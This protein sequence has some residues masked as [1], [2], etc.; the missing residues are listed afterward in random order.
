MGLKWN[1]RS[2][3]FSDN[4]STA[5]F[6]HLTLSADDIDGD[7]EPYSIYVENRGKFVPPDQRISYI[8]RC[9]D[10]FGGIDEARKRAEYLARCYF[11][12][13][14]PVYTD[15]EMKNGEVGEVEK[16]I[17]RKPSTMLHG[18]WVRGI[19]YHPELQTYI[20]V[21][22]IANVETNTPHPLTLLM[23]SPTVIFKD[24]YRDRKSVV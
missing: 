12:G 18:V 13:I 8:F 20:R 7:N 2:G 4:Y 6:G 14:P 1:S 10:H 17:Q 5:R 22:S 9:D 11:Y 23:A 24:V 16:A 21:E 15:W 3:R 19:Y